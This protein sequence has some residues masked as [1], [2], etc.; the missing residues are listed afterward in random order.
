MFKTIIISLI[1]LPFVVHAHLGGIVGKVIDAKTQQPLVG[2]NL[3]IKGQTQGTRTNDLGMFHVHNLKPATYLVE[4]SFLGYATEQKEVVVADDEVVSINFSLKTVDFSLAEVKVVANN[5]RNQQLISSLDMK[6][7]TINN[8]QDVLRMI[9]GLFIGQH[10]GGGKAEQL[11]LRGFDLDHGTDINLT[12]DG[13]PI[14]MVSHAHGQGY[15]DAHFII[16]ELIENVAFKKGLYDADKGNFTTAGWANYQTKKVLDQNFIKTEIGQFN[17]YRLVGAVNL[18]GTKAA[19]RNQS[20]FLASEYNYSDAYFENPQ[21]FKRFN[22]FGKYHGHLRENTSLTFTASTFWSRWDASGQIPDRAVADGSIGFYGAIDPNEGGTTSRTNLNAELST[23]VR[24]NHVWKNQFFYSNYHF[25]LYS[26]FTFYLEDSL[27]GDQIKQ[28]EARNLWG[29]NS[30]YSIGHQL[31]NRAATLALGLNYRHDMTNNSELSHTKNRSETLEQ[32]QLGDINEAN[33]G[34]FVEETVQLSPKLSAIA[35]LRFDYFHNQYTDHL[36]NNKR[37]VASA[38]IVSPKFNLYYTLNPKL[39]FYSTSGKGFHSNDTRVVVAQKGLEV[40]PAAYGSDLGTIWKPFPQMVINAAYWYLWLN[41]E[42]VYV[43]DAGV[44]EPSGKSVRSGWDVSIRYQLA[45][46][47]FIDTDLNW[48]KP[49]A[50]GM[51]TGQ[52]YLPLAPVFTSIGGITLKNKTGFSG[53]IRYRYMADRPA[54][55]DNTIVAKGYFVSDVL[56]SY[57]H[58]KTTIGLSVQNVFNTKWKET[59]F[60]TESRLQHET[61]SVEEIHF[62]PGTPFNAKL[63]VSYLF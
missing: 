60:A 63:S 38:S 61:T 7:R 21:H 15:A 13:V 36:A 3:V 6:L 2:A 50:V 52:D 18:L 62:T 26:N 24:P 5:P 22:L 1:M 10:A 17:T 43:G 46:N 35:G 8:S 44:V 55:E 33:L 40:L 39:Q 58:K 57:T 56:V 30:S 37:S 45:K 42:F 54:N 48:A 49:R 47:I 32:F 51:A 9:P 16:P 25:E 27:N 11:F 14:N 19:A 59:Q 34:T 29:Y 28:K 12:V 41:Q 31:G 20:A 4:V 23:L 53:S